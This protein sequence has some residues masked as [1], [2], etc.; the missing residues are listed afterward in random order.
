MG[1]IVGSDESEEGELLD[2]ELQCTPAAARR[3]KVA[4]LYGRGLPASEIAEQLGLSPRM[5]ASDIV[6]I[7]RQWREKVA[8]NVDSLIAEQLSRYNAIEREAWEMW[9]KSKLDAESVTDSDE[10]GRSTTV[11]GQSGNPAY[12]DIIRKTGES[13]SKLLGIERKTPSSQTNI[14][15]NNAPLSRDELLAQ[16]RHLLA[17]K[18][19]LN[20]DA[21]LP[22][23]GRFHQQEPS[24]EQP[25]CPQPP[26][27]PPPEPPS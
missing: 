26:L 27:K 24:P 8:A 20:P 2:V 6:V 19:D 12:L 13:R 22:P 21:I 18:L 9:D 11:K 7:R 25:G 3:V 5:V 1:E 10:G 16:A 23:P 4:H 17:T 14:Q 15:I